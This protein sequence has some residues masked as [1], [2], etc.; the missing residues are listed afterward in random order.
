M[1]LFP[2]GNAVPVHV[3]F[4]IGNACSIH[5]AAYILHDIIPDIF[6]G[7]IQQQL[8]PSQHRGKAVCQC[9]VRVEAVEIRIGID[10]F[11]L[12]PEAEFHALGTNSVRQF[13]Q[14]TGQFLFV[15]PVVAQARLVVLPVTEPAV[16][17]NKEFTAQ[18]FGP[19]GQVQKP[20]L[21]EIKHAAFP[22]VVQHRP[23][24]ILPG[25][26]HNMVIDETVHI[27]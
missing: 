14:T 26:G 6:P 12:K 2:Q 9:P 4:H 23:K 5:D 10:G 8:M 22:A 15:H 1:G 3:P 24:P 27:F 18:G 11:R 17:Q 20:G 16:I 7:K 25:S 19:V 21:I 13:F